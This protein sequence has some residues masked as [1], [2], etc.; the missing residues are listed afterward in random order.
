MNK[1][2]W[3]TVPAVAWLGLFFA[4]PVLGI[5]ALSF[6]GRDSY[7]RIVYSFTAENYIRALDPIYVQIVGET[8]LL[9]IVTTV[10][11]ALIGYPFAYAMTQFQRKW[12]N[13]LLLLILVPFWINMLVRSFA[14]VILLRSQGVINTLLER[15]G[16]IGEP[17]QLLYN[18]EAVFLGMVYT[19]LPFVILP[20]YVTLEKIDKSWLE[21][22]SDLGAAPR[23]AFWAVVW[24]MSLPGVFTGCMLVFVSSIGMFVIPDI[25]G[26]AK[27]QLLG[28]VIQNQFLSARDW[29]FGAALSVYLIILSL[30]AIGVMQSWVSRLTGAGGAKRG[31]T[32]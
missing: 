7:G 29:P 12:Q 31:G 6:M 9:A 3:L 23:R 5:G 27:S 13:V 16:W 25:M 24:P 8:L 26:G 11:C 22:A 1:G 15:L 30:A 28:N 4:V 14:W 21:A 32:M 10:L 20:V 2:G 18:K 19:L 17:L